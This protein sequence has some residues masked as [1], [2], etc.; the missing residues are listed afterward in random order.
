VASTWGRRHRLRG[1]DRFRTGL[2][3]RVVRRM[4]WSESDD[5][6]TW[7]KGVTRATVLGRWHQEKL[8]MWQELQAAKKDPQRRREMRRRAN[9]RW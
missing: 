6:S 2:T 8:R 3:F 4:L 7:R 1:Y 9:E 5:K